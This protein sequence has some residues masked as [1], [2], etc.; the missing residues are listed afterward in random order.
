MASVDPYIP[1]L[2]GSSNEV[3]DNSGVIHVSIILYS[4]IIDVFTGS[5]GFLTEG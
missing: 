2:D 5:P 4:Y 3:S 1:G